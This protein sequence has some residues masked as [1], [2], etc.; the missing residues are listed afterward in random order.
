MATKP[1]YEELSQKVKLL[2]KEALAHK[3]AAKA[4]LRLEKAVAQS[5]D[6]IAMADL[7]GK[8][9]FVNAAWAQMHGYTLEELIG[10]HLST[11]HTV[12][13]M[14]EEVI[15]FN[16]RMMEV[17]ANQ[18]EIGH[19]RSDGTTFPTW[20]SATL[21][22]DDEENIAGLLGIARDITDQKNVEKKM[23]ENVVFFES[24][25]NSIQ[26]GISVLDRDCNIVRVNK[27]MEEMYS[28]QMPLIGKKCYSVFQQRQSP[29][30]WCPSIPTMET[31]EAH[32]EIVPYET[33]DCQT[34]WIDL[35]TFPLKDASGSVVGIIE[36]VKDITAHKNAEEA[37]WKSE[38]KYKELANS[39]PQIIFETDESSQVTFA[40]HDAFNVFGYSQAEFDKGLNALD[41][42]IPKDRERALENMQRVLNG[43]IL[44]GI[45]YTA[46]RKDGSTFP[47]IIHSNSIILENK[48]VGL[49]GIMIDLSE[50]KRSEKSM[51]ESEFRFRSLFDLSPQPIALAE[52]DSGAIINVNAKFCETSKYSLE[53]LIGRHATEIGLYSKNDREIFIKELQTNG[54]VHGLKMDFKA[55]DGSVIKTLM[56]ARPVNIG[57]K[58]CIITVFHDRTEQKRLESQL[59]QAH[60]MEAIGTLAGGIAHDFNNL[61]FPIIGYT[62]MLIDTAPEGSE[63]RDYLE[64]IFKEALRAR[65]LVRQILTFS[66]QT[67]QELKPM[68]VQP[69]VKE[70]LK[71]LRS[72]IPATIQFNWR[73]DDACGVIMG[74]PTQIHQVI[75]N[76]CT[77]A[78]HAMEETGGHLE[79]SLTEIELGAGDMPDDVDLTP[80]RY[81]Q[82]TV[83]DTGQGIESEVLNRIFDPYFTTKEE[84]KGTGLGLAVVH[85]IIKEHFGDIRV[86]SESGKGSVF[87]VYLPVIEI[88]DKETEIAPEPVQ[89]GSERVLL[90][91]DEET[92]VHMAQRMLEWLGYQVTS[93]TSSI[94]ALEAF[95]AQPDK[96][97]LVITDMT[98]PNMSGEILAEELKKIRSDIPVIL[99]TG[100]S[101]KIS[102][103]RATALGIE[104]FLMKPTVMRDLAK[105]IREVL[106]NIDK[107]E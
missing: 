66:R 92:I 44:G 3:S 38:E 11:F 65:D 107:D 82:L 48:P 53:E 96:F 33:E 47:A 13:Q 59:R 26:D 16:Q 77:N 70:A 64:E 104:G 89:I 45:E 102:K 99:C 46:L 100:F 78:Y 37:F 36:Y 97:D 49:R 61:L 31:G 62:E 72:S 69:V 63:R 87:H 60:R 56:F 4:L 24:V 103:D 75:M 8:I 101:E 18:S 5:I 50:Q 19:V 88:K 10:R 39:L 105:T 91:D 98:M 95:R 67:I 23:I 71:L 6:G 35:T 34:G 74:D 52:Q 94:E 29:C 7:E 40:N 41:M 17:G 85:G 106:D 80:G 79:V 83:T 54:E 84:G 68:R 15:P 25:F 81:I 51:R 20:M 12:E 55:K 86:F 1:T 9:Q 27:R 14:Q 30:P 73:I 58:S 42:L 22:K 32:A 28:R 76:L 90:V 2:E 21:L 93:R 43:E 57:G